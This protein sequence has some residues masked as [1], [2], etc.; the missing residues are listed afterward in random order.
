MSI[1]G[2]GWQVMIQIDTLLEKEKKTE[3]LSCHSHTLVSFKFSVAPIANH[4]LLPKNR[5]FWEIVSKKHFPQQKYSIPLTLTAG[6]AR[7]S[8]GVFATLSFTESDKVT[9][10]LPT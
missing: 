9:A 10:F 7:D 5:A 2:R 6:T 1:E 3:M 8:G 4:L